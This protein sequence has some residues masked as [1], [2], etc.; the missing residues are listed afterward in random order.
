MANIRAICISEKKGMQKHPVSEA[1][2]KADWGIVGDAHAG[3]WHRQISILA[4]DSVARMQEKLPH[5]QL[6]PG[7]FAENILIDGLDL[8]TVAIGQQIQFGT[9]V[10]GEVTQ[11]GKECHNDCI[12]R[13][14]AGD[15]V[16]PREGVFLKVI[17]PGIIKVGN[18]VRLL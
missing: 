5:Y 7:D 15:C 6:K 4:Q 11:I 18:K 12:I 16:M 8:K 9:D 10:I 13:K 3:N 2:L 17:H 14:T 1:E